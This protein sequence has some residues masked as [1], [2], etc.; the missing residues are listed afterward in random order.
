MI[1]GGKAVAPDPAPPSAPAVINFA[2]THDIDEQAAFL[3]GWNQTYAQTSAGVFSGSIQEIVFGGFHLFR[4]ETGSSLYQLGALPSDVYAVGLPLRLSGLAT[5]CGTHCDGRSLHVFSGSDG[6]E[7]HTPGGLVMSGLVLTKAT[8]TAAF[9]GEDQDAILR[10][11]NYPHLRR[12]PLERLGALR[13][14]LANAFELF[15]ASPEIASS[16]NVVDAVRS[17]LISNLSYA[18]MDQNGVDELQ[19]RPSRRWQIVRDAVDLTVQNVEKPLTVAELC[20]GL[21][22]SRRTLQYCFHEVLGIAPAVFLRAVRL[23]GARRTLKTASSVTEA[24]CLWGFLHFGRFAQDYKSMFGERPSD[25]FIRY[26]AQ[27]PRN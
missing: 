22:V 23:S 13:L 17:A 25:T 6:F 20:R 24:A 18:L 11:L 10:C 15:H 3:K 21:D 9:S 16:S 5:F 12:A 2:K 7:F 8:I 26:H 4:E 19:I 14:V 1:E 27:S